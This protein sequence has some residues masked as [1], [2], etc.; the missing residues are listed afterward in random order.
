MAGSKG[1]RDK[2]KFNTARADQKLIKMVDLVTGRGLV[3]S[4]QRSDF[5]QSSELNTTSTGTKSDQ[6]LFVNTL[7]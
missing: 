3:D 4:V 7:N 1:V 2:T 6:Q 5:S